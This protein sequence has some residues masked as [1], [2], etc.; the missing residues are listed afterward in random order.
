VDVEVEGG[1]SWWVGDVDWTIEE[2][3]HTETEVEVEERRVCASLIQRQ[4]VYI[5]RGN[6]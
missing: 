5:Y 4:L 1:L 6:T 2:D 3:E